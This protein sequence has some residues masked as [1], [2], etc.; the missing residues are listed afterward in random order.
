M[1]KLTERECRALDDGIYSTDLK[2]YIAILPPTYIIFPSCEL[3]DKLRESF[4]LEYHRRELNI[5]LEKFLQEIE[6]L[7]K[8]EQE[9]NERTEK[10]SNF[11]ERKKIWQN[12]AE[13]RNEKLIR[14]LEHELKVWQEY[15]MQSVKI[16][17][18]DSIDRLEEMISY[19]P[20]QR[21]A[22]IKLYNDYINVL[23]QDSDTR[24]KTKGFRDNTARRLVYIHTYLRNNGYINCNIDIWLYWFSEK[25][26]SYIPDRIN[27]LK[28]DAVLSALIKQ[29]CDNGTERYIQKAFVFNKKYQKPKAN[30]LLF[31]KIKECMQY[32]IN[33][34]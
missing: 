11:L 32:A 6:D 2:E 21:Q 18:D 17:K 4:S 14:I 9:K 25:E 33:K 16:F 20:P 13:F 29:V 22:L 8:S 5:E 34:L 10:F 28:S 26:L 27:W 7:P 31:N 1:R 3:F 30:N 24:L 19:I 15:D 12:S 23:K